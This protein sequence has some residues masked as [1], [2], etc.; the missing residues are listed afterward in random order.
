MP[1]HLSQLFSATALLAA[2]LVTSAPLRL[3]TTPPA[4]LT[5]R[6]T[7][8]RYTFANCA[9]SATG[10]AYAAIFWYYPDYLPDFPEPQAMAYV[11][12]DAAVEFAGRTTHVTTP[13]TLSASLP[14]NATDAAVGDF[15][16]TVASASS[17]VGPMAVVKG[18]GAVFYSPETNVDC[19]E[20]YWQRDVSYSQGVG[21]WCGHGC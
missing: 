6:D 12:T 17:F 9:N 7:A 18:S 20:E 1:S 21:G 10:E 13:F 19:Y 14:V 16:S 15:V 3:P 4:G 5:A 2:A 11:S 8:E